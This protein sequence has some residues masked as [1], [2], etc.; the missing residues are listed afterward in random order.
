M[1]DHLPKTWGFIDKKRF[2]KTN[3]IWVLLRKRPSI[4][5][6]AKKVE[7]HTR[8][9]KFPKFALII[10]KLKTTSHCAPYTYLLELD[11]ADGIQC[12][13]FA[14]VP[15]FVQVEK[16]D[17]YCFEC[18]MHNMG[19]ARPHNRRMSC[20]LNDIYVVQWPKPL[21]QITLSIAQIRGP[22]ANSLRERDRGRPME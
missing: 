8:P 10:K 4:L 18:A 21:A 7:S 2:Q 9:D 15:S 16:V 19:L 22:P 12:W 5:N 13:R 6:L 14:I 20:W 3:E 11:I 1:P 17:R